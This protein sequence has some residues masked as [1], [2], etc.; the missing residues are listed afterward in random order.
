MLKE[1]RAFLLRGNIVDLAVAVV[2]GVAFGAVVDS[3]VADIITPV[4]AAIGGQPD[5]STLHFT[6]NGSR[7][8]YGNFINTVIAFVITAA[9]IFFLVVKPMTAMLARIKKGEE[10]AAE[11]VAPP[12]WEYLTAADGDLNT[13]GKQGWELV[14]VQGSGTFLF[15]RPLSA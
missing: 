6:I 2:I 15:K 11:N 13:L 14:G 12:T 10:T 8:N 1:F 7:F 5:F 3:L 9:A 4:I